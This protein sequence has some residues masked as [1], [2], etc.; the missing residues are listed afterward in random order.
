MKS[1]THNKA[2][3]QFEKYGLLLTDIERVGISLFERIKPLAHTKNI[4]HL[5][6][7]GKNEDD[8]NE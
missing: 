5:A 2:F 7:S 8:I 1:R 6:D 3:S 4:V